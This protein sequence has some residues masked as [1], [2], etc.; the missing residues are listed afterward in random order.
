MARFDRH[1]T[2]RLVL[3]LALAAL[4]QADGSQ[5]LFEAPHRIEALATALAA[6]APQRRLTLCRELTKQFETIATMVAAELPAWLGAEAHR[7]R[8]EFALV[9]HAVPAAA[10]AADALPAKALRALQLLLRELPLKQAVALA[11]EWS[12]APCNALY[13][14]ALAL[15][16][17][18][19]EPAA[20]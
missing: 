18:G 17:A 12:G 7:C 8:G 10:A 20:D 1:P 3:V 9:L 19:A 16:D 13:Q 11:A 14:Q 6:A 5:V 4:L 15:R 2:F